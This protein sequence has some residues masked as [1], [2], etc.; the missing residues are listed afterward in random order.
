MDPQQRLLLERGY[1]ALYAAEKCRLLLSSSLTGVF[2]RVAALEYAELLAA[3]PASAS[4]YALTGS[5]HSIAS[6]RLS[7]ML[8]LHGVVRHMTACA[9]RRLSSTTQWCAP[10]C[11]ANAPDVSQQV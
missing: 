1:E 8:G 10:S 6:G 7:Y 4:V 2:L 3:S 9:R 11:V 5:T